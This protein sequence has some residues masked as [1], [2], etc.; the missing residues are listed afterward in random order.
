MKVKV[1]KSFGAPGA[2][3]GAIIDMPTG[4]DWI[5]AGLVEKA[6]TVQPGEKVWTR[7]EKKAPKK[8]AK[9]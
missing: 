1:L 4:A 9:K 3:E 2:S 7:T 5:E 8:K 6:G